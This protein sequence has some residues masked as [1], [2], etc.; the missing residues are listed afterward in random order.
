MPVSIP[1]L[2]SNLPSNIVQYTSIRW[3]FLSHSYEGFPMHIVR[4][5]EEINF[6]DALFILSRHSRS[7]GLAVAVAMLL[8][9][10]SHS[11][12][13]YMMRQF[14]SLAMIEIGEV[15]VEGPNGGSAALIES[16]GLLKLKIQD[17]YLPNALSRIGDPSN[18]ISVTIQVPNN[19]RLVKLRA[20]GADPKIGAEVLRDVFKQ[21]IEDHKKLSILP[22]DRLEAR[23]RA[24]E[25]EIASAEN[26]KK[27]LQKQL[28]FLNK[29][30]EMTRKRL[31]EEAHTASPNEFY[32]R[33]LEED[34]EVALP[35]RE[36]DIRALID[37]YDSRILEARLVQDT[38]RSELTNLKETRSI[39]PLLP[40]ETIPLGRTVFILLAGL[41]TAIVAITV[42]IFFHA[43]RLM[44]SRGSGAETWIRDVPSR[45]PE[46]TAVLE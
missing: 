16:S 4:D 1:K 44:R 33:T 25:I 35:Q 12:Y 32:L 8:A 46:K 13:I 26:E 34:L 10:V 23:I 39:L 19:M 36:A 27:I 3:R 42:V 11:L 6:L 43:L 31:V 17:V 18:K 38:I 45:R 21:I 24:K 14:V 22:R 20:L 5:A 30:R 28:D 2:R 29:D 41:V 9:G 40:Q 15:P 37:R 7:V